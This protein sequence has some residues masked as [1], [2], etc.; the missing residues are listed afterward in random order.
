MQGRGDKNRT[1]SN[2]KGAKSRKEHGERGRKV[3]I[4]KKER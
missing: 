3:E 4:K 2:E 1:S